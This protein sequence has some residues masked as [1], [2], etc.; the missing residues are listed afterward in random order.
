MGRRPGRSVLE[1]R[2]IFCNRGDLRNEADVEQN[3]ARRLIES[4]GYA[5]KAIRPKAALEELSIGPLGGA[6]KYR[7]DF[8]IKASAHIRWILEA[9]APSERLDNHFDQAQGYCEAINNSYAKANPVR[10]FIL[11]NGV[12]TRIYEAGTT[13]PILTLK[14][15]HFIENNTGYRSLRE[16]LRPGMFSGNAT[17][18]D[19][20]VIHF[21]K[22][23]I[24]EVNHVFAKCH[25]HIHQS[26]HIS[27]AKGFEEFVKL[28][29]LKLLSDKKV[30]DEYPGVLAEKRFDYPSDEVTFSLHWVKNHAQSTPNPV[31]SILFKGFMEDVE[32]QIAR[33]VRKRFFDEN[34]HIE[35]RPET[36]RGVVE[37]LEKLFLFGIDADLNGRLFENFLGATMRGKDL[38]QYFTPRTLV[39]MGV[40]LGDLKITDYVLDG[41]CGTGGF[42]IDALADMWAKVNSNT[43]L[44]NQVKERKRKKIAQ[45]QIYG[46]DFAKSPNLAKIARLNMY[47][48][49]D[50]GSRI[51]NVDS[52][53]LCVTSDSNDIPEE[54]TDPNDTP[55][56]TVEKDEMR[57]LGFFEK[58]NVVLTNPPFSKQYERD[59]EG[60]ERILDQYKVAEDKE[61]V[62]AKQMFFEMYHH[63]LKPGGRLISV[64]D[65]GFLSGRDHKHFR[66]WLRRQYIIKAVI[67]LPGDAFQRSDARV[68]TSFIVLEKRETSKNHSGDDQPSIF[69]YACRYVGIDDPKR[70]RWLPG[71]EELRNN[72]QNE[73]EEVVREYQAF[74]CGQGDAQY[75]VPANRAHD[76]LDVKRCLAMPNERLAYWQASNTTTLLKLS[77]VVS[78]KTFDDGEVIECKDHDDYVQYFTVKYEGIAQLGDTIFP[79]TE[80]QYSQLYRVRQGDIVISNIAVTYGSVAI[81]PQ[82]LDGTVVS[83]EYTVLSANPGFD[84]RVV[85]AVLRSPEIR[86]ALLLQT[87]GA[88]RTRIRWDDVQGIPFPYPNE[89]K[90]TRIVQHIEAAEAARIQA[91]RER[92]TAIEELNNALHLNQDEAH[93]ILEAFKPPS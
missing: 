59:K 62:L 17:P 8:A 77:D 18:A 65:D 58:F 35:L 84:A 66:N 70:Q 69:M 13:V 88:N 28:I 10:Y 71:D 87:T 40:G 68:K 33:R 7:P 15:K 25:Q 36:I 44:S 4:L 81:V 55:E 53:D 45:E 56:E 2:N 20:D 52:L 21:M 31:D 90:V 38:G 73:V 16:M 9:K 11:T 41:C 14:F 80:T 46:I 92:T 83:K 6:K 72:A 37:Q 39:K 51:F 30:K 43:S 82:E 24:A 63:Y 23:S 78:P 60:D 89:E 34:G 19:A 61:K 64:I 93:R 85:W 5:D 67:S 79:K 76:R 29:T 22:P 75:I 27:Q 54:N 48:H 26:D 1:Q 12:E 74:L 32:K 47:L 49:G 57:D 91:L 86:A 42:L 50:G 3:F